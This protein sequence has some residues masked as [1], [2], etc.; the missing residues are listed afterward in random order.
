M[1]FLQN[2]ENCFC[3][4]IVL[5]LFCFWYYWRVVIIVVPGQE[6]RWYIKKNLG[7]GILDNRQYSFAKLWAKLQFICCIVLELAQNL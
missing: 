5:S 3:L 6:K 1:K 7:M 2:N 4:Q